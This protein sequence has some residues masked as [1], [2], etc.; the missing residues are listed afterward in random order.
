[1][2]LGALGS[3]AGSVLGP[4]AGGIF[5][6]SSDRRARQLN[7][8]QNQE[9]IRL[10]R[11]GLGFSRERFG[12]AVGAHRQGIGFLQRAATDA[13]AANAQAGFQAFRNVSRQVQGQLGSLASQQGVRGLAS[14]SSGLNARGRL[15]R[16]AGNVFG[17]IGA[18]VGQADANIALSG[19]RG[20]AAGFQ[21]L[22]NAFQQQGNTEAQIQ[23]SIARIPLE[24]E[25][26]SNPN[27]ATGL[28]ALGGQI[29]AGLAAWRQFNLDKEGAENA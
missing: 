18:Q 24:L 11:L 12:Q 29:D 25:F 9:S 14:G 23:S 28:G 27:I 13:R 16:E 21:Q 17:N 7:E 5:Q 6:N 3:I 26:Q 1:M 10:A 22:G 8:A 20:V 15:L 19:G 4:I 2:P